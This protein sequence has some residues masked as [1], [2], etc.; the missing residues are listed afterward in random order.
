MQH[1]KGNFSI[2]QQE[3]D[4]TKK[5]L[6]TIIS[7]L[8]SKFPNMKKQ[9]G[10]KPQTTAT[11]Q[12]PT[13]P[14][15]QPGQAPTPLNAANL[16]QQQQQLKMHQRSNSR[17]SHTPAAPTSEQPPIQIGGAR[18]PNG[19]PSYLNNNTLTQE[20]MHI[21]PA[22][23]K[24]KQNSTPA[25]VPGQGTPGSTASP[26]VG[27]A[28]S[29]EMKRQIEA[30]S[31]AKFL[32]CPEP[33]C[34]RSNVTFDNQDALEAHRIED[35]V[36]P[37]ENP[38]KFVQESLTSVSGLDS[39]GHSKK[40][41]SQEPATTST[42]APNGIKMM[43]ASSKQG[44]T[45]S[46]KVEIAST[47]TTPM[48]RQVSMHRQSS[49]AGVKTNQQPSADSAKDTSSKTKQAKDSARQE[50]PPLAAADPWATATIDPTELSQFFQP[51]ESGAGGAISDMNV[52]RSITP[53]DTPESSKDGVSEPNSDISDGV[54][55]DINL[56]VDFD[57]SWA[58]F[59]PS[60]T[61]PLF[62][63]D[64][65][66]VNG[67]M[68]SQV[69]FDEDPMAGNFSSWD[70]MVVPSVFDKPFFFD[71]SLYSMNVD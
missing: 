62:D 25:P 24:Q 69:M 8:S 10:P 46:A 42:S 55:L 3:F 40:P 64:N 59:G 19:A 16:Q 51:F 29:P 57:E 9:D 36:K 2:T 4:N 32:T 7:D 65:F 54:A 12:A 18:S 56:D 34:E 45:P 28:T 71:T 39:Q 67:G 27:K 14:Q 58:P 44:H 17:S 1:L 61:K 15:S 11:T 22:R 23:K 33:E 35:H 52:Y 38:L 43:Q 41:S 47:A 63:I 49:A 66:D 5:L 48:I 30:K 13:Q 21:P 26:Q 70:E 53:N 37:L 31:Q 50:A 6:N 60:D 68:D 20:K